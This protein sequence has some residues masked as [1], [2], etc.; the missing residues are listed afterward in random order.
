[1]ATLVFLIIVGTLV[2]LDNRMCRWRR[3]R[4]QEEAQA[5]LRHWQS[6]LPPQPEDWYSHLH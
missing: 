2:Y 4:A 6:F 3:L 5:A 1:M